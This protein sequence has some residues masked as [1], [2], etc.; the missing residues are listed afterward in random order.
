MRQLKLAHSQQ[1]QSIFISFLSRVSFPR[2]GSFV[3]IN[4]KISIDCL[5][6]NFFT[7]SLH[8]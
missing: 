3:S 8:P 2:G 4:L 6:Q 5:W 1:F 7:P